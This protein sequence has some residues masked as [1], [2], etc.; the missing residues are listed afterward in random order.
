MSTSLDQIREALSPYLSDQTGSVE[1][2]ENLLEMLEYADQDAKH[3]AEQMEGMLALYAGN[4]VS[5]ETLRNRL[6]DL[7][8]PMNDLV[9]GDPL[10]LGDVPIYDADKY[11]GTSSGT[12]STVQVAD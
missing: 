12:S 9:I 2:P 1:L 10:V 11:S 4:K 6:Q 3:R 7:T 5:R 8:L